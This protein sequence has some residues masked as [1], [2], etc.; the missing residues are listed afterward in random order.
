VWR[1]VLDAGLQIKT[2]ETL[3]SSNG[4][5]EKKKPTSP[6]REGQ[7]HYSHGLTSSVTAA[8]IHHYTPETW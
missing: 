5:G 1:R 8:K 6:V 4:V 2:N 7:L 3:I